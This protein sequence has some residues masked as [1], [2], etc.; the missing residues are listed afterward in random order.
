MAEA[1]RRV[2]P[3]GA[4]PPA[5]EGGDALRTVGQ[6]AADEPVPEQ[7]VQPDPNELERTSVP[8]R[9]FVAILLL[10]VLADVT[11]Y[12]GYGFAG[13]GLLFFAAPWLLLLGATRPR[14]SWS[15][16]IVNLMLTLLAARMA[17]C[18]S[19]VGVTLGA[20]LLIGFAMSL[21]GQR[22]YVLETAV[23]A[24]QTL[25]AGYR[26]LLHYTRYLRGGR[27]T[28][29]RKGWLSLV[30][31][32]LVSAVFSLLF[33]LANPDLLTFLGERVSL[34]CE[35]LRDWLLQFAPTPWEVIFWLAVLWISVGLLRPV[36][37]AMVITAA[38]DGTQHLADAPAAAG[39]AALYPAC[40]NTLVAVILL[41]AL[42]L[43]FEFQTLWFREF[44]A[45]FYYSGY[46]HEG[47]AWLTVALGLATVILSFVFAGGMLRDA[48]LPRLKRLAWWWSL[49]NLLLAVAVYHRMFIYVGFNGMTRMRIV[50]LFGMSAV[51]AGFL[52]VL[53]KIARNRDFVWLVRQ[54]LW[55]LAV[56]IYLFAITPVD[57]IWVDYDVRRILA[58]DPAPAVQISYHP[59]TAEGILLLRPLLD[60]EDVLIRE[61]VAAMLAQ[62]EEAAE[63]LATRCQN[64]G[65]TS[66][67][68]A[69]QRLLEQL[70][71]TRGR[72]A[73][74]AD[75]GERGAARQRFQTYA[76]RWY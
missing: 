34:L 15:V 44:P 25:W 46:A 10:I 56:T 48:R 39:S 40:R 72:W 13:Y 68:W 30:L 33:V 57:A 5:G 8:W 71:L 58:G 42:Y 64:Q 60:C 22:P 67:Q 16:W 11:V 73:R 54:Q 36:V 45:G 66:Y 20:A 26:G 2:S 14:G 29:R 27:L 28:V 23:F 74:Y 69:E 35:T 9:E 63:Q 4:G 65:W 49:E 41:F 38:P 52:M 1:S 24:S 31:P 18:G 19:S 3:G 62:E 32:L 21:S 17:W 55:A 47:A 70:R 53:W 50:G 76:Y 12:R 51:V 37:D 61:G 7:P 75:L 6:G 43:V 59:I